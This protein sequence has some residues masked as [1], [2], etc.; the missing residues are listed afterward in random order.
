MAH[1]LRTLT[2]VNK[3]L[4]AALI[5]AVGAVACGWLYIHDVEL[6]LRGGRKVML[7]AAARELAPGT[8]LTEAD[9]ALRAMPEAY[10]HPESVMAT[11]TDEKKV[12]GRVVLEHLAQGQPVLWSDFESEKTKLTRGLAAVVQKGQRAITLPVDV[13]GS[14]ANQL[15]PA[16]RVDILGTFSRDKREVTVTVLQNVLV[17]STN[18]RKEEG[19]DGE[20]QM[21]VNA[22]TLSLDLDEAEV[23]SF[24]RR[25]GAIDFV[26]HGADDIDVVAEVAQK[27]FGDLFEDGKRAQLASRRVRRRVEALRPDRGPDAQPTVP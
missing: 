11:A 7:L 8:R 27:D 2:R 14:F 3:R 26:L 15:R 21:V 1:R 22:I 25:H 16:D 9:L 13:S 24:A 18:G 6:G 20:K 19:P 10:V 5:C 17:L 23:L 4:L 12:L